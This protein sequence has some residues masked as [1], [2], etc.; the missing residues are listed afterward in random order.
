MTVSWEH[1]AY[2]GDNQIDWGKEGSPS[3]RRMGDLPEA[4]KWVR[5]EIPVERWVS[6]PGPRST[7]GRSLS[8]VVR[9]IGITPESSSQN[10]LLSVIGRLGKRPA[11]QYAKHVAQADS[12]RADCRN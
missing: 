3:R 12:D 7:A 9:S 10:G 11:G 6:N 8:L 1:R 2:W 4:G 5:L